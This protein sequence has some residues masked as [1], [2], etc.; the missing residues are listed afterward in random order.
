[1]PHGLGHYL[2]L[3]THDVGG[4]QQN[5]QGL[6]VSAPEEHPTLRITRTIDDDHV[7]TIEPG[8]YFIPTLL[9]RL[10]ESKHGK[11]FDWNKIES[12]LPCGGIRI[13]DNICMDGGKAH[14]LTRDCFQS[15]KV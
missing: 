7:F 5:R 12:L 13:E 8:I 3:Q 9:K 4:Y 1:M 6:Q 2:G 14:N 15:Q 10:R 11:Q